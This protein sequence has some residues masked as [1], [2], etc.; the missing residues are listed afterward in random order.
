MRNRRGNT[1]RPNSIRE[2]LNLEANVRALVPKAA[3]FGESS[4]FELF[5]SLPPLLIRLLC[6][7]SITALVAVLS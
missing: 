1:L 6:R 2:E 5:P 7:H 3:E 4:K